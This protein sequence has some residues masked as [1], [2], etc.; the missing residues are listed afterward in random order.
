VVTSL[1]RCSLLSNAHLLSRRRVIIVALLV[2]FATG[3]LVQRRFDARLP[4][5]IRWPGRTQR[6]PGARERTSGFTSRT[7]TFRFLAFLAERGG[8]RH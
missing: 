5:E 4:T 1:L 8:R 6:L 3:V 2:I 7:R